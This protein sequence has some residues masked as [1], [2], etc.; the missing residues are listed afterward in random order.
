MRRWSKAVV[1]ASHRLWVSEMGTPLCHILVVFARSGSV[2]CV[3]VYTKKPGTLANQRIIPR[4]SNPRAGNSGTMR[5]T[6]AVQLTMARRRR[7][8]AGPCGERRDF[9]KIERRARE[10][11]ISITRE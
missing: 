11:G 2:F 1:D 3:I 10:V 4:P 5:V 6:S 7:G 8:L 9:E